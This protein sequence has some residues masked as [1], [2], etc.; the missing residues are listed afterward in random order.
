[1]VRLLRPLMILALVGLAI[2]VS[3]T[4]PPADAQ[5][6]A[7]LLADSIELDGDQRLIALGNVEIFFQGQSLHASRLSYDARLDA[8][9]IDG[10]IRLDDGNGN[11]LLAE[12]AQLSADLTTGILTSARLVLASRLQ[13]A[14][15]EIQRSG[16]GRYTGLAQV[17]AS[18]CQICAGA[19]PLWEIRARSV[20][21][22]SLEDQLYFTGAQL[23]FAGVPVFYLPRLRMP[24]PTVARAAGFLMPRLTSSTALGLGLRL[25]YFLPIGPSRDLTFTPYVT[26]K[27]RNSLELRYREALLHGTYTVTAALS[28]DNLTSG[29]LR[30]Y[31]TA[32]GSLD[33]GHDFIASF[34]GT[35]VSDG[36]Y[37]ADYG[38]SDADRLDSR[39]TAT[40]TRRNEYISAGIIGFQSLRD[41]ENDGT[42]PVMVSDFTFHRRFSSQILGGAAGFQ[43][44]THSH[45]RP[46][47]DGA[48]LDGDGIG[49]GRDVSRLSFSGEWRRNWVMP[50]GLVFSTIA[51]AYA[52][53]YS[54]G[55]DTVYAGNTLRS[56]AILAS[57]L[58][59]PWSRVDGN[60]HQLIEP[61]LQLVLAPRSNDLVPNEDSALVEFDQG[62][63]FA[64]NRFPGTD[65]EESG[66]H[67]NMGLT[68]T[69]A[70]DGGMSLGLTAGR[71]LRFS[72]QHQFSD[73]SGLAG[74]RSAWLV[75]GSLQVEGLSLS[76]R[77]QL[78]DQLAPTKT[79][80]R[81]DLTRD[82]YA[83][84]MGF[85]DLASDA[86]ENRLDPLREA[87]LDGS[88]KLSG[89]WTATGETRYD[90]VTDRAAQMGI[91]V[92]FL[93]ECLSLD[94]SVSRRFA[95]STSVGASTD[96]GLSVELLGF[97]STPSGPA[98][99]CRQ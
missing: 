59:W 50:A 62:N 60:R 79:E 26:S 74:T 5:D 43:V 44:Q 19:P 11:V 13:L 68:Y 32:E 10:P 52:D 83:L 2:A 36:S 30:G 18:S 77:S 41:G 24:D 20:L 37:L 35:V 14:A 96:F 40:R 34:T 55:Q 22:D 85:S 9:V 98:R 89:N 47:T 16:G 54:V 42:S 56:H 8:L 23:R 4:A 93:N 38:I 72:D 39:L 46:S 12:Q 84:A 69:L 29:H 82:R 71:V 48:D 27:G 57:E 17:A 33:I 3:M 64:L 67:V 51:E 63:L 76:G 81:L 45:Y 65:G 6:R 92:S 94:L 80:L 78:N 73:A 87:V 53:F 25:P 88:Y 66:A 49:D 75:A 91:G 70:Y 31:A 15:A 90:F 1:M 7:T 97:G 99:Q 58:R 86:A 61:V 28:Q 95:S 21:H